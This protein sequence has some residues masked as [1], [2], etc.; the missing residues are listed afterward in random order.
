MLTPSFWLGDRD[1]RGVERLHVRWSNGEETNHT[2][3]ELK[4]RGGVSWLRRKPN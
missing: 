3:E 2:A 1:W 4:H